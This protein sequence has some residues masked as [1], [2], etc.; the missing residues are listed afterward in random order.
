MK[1]NSSDDFW[2]A[3][4]IQQKLAKLWVCWVTEGQNKLR[5][6]GGDI[7]GVLD[8]EADQFLTDWT[9]ARAGLEDVRDIF[10]SG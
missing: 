2:D 9:K 5:D 3:S 6:D 7:L 10:H 4:T 8:G 1:L